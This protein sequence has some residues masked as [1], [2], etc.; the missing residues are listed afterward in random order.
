MIDHSL[1]HPTITDKQLLEGCEIAKVNEVASVF[2]KP[3]A[4]PL[5]VEALEGSSLSVG[6]VIGFPQGSSCMDIKVAETA[7]Y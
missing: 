4:I 7:R 3:Y 6:T 5:A 1:L 2:I